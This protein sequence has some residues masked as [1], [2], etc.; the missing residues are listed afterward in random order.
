MRVHISSGQLGGYHATLW[1]RIISVGVLANLQVDSP[2]LCEHFSLLMIQNHDM[3]SLL[4][5]E[6]QQYFILKSAAHQ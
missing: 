4:G 2:L 3:A 5:A 1:S 6:N